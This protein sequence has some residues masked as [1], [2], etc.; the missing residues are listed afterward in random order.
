MKTKERARRSLWKKGCGAILLAF[1][2]AMTGQTSVNDSYSPWDSPD[3][4]LQTIHC[5]VATSKA[6]NFCGYK[7]HE[8]IGND[9]PDSASSIRA[10]VTSPTEK[11]AVILTGDWT[12]PG[13]AYFLDLEENAITYTF[14]DTLSPAKAVFSADGNHLFLTSVIGDVLVV[15]I[16]KGE[17]GPSEPY[18]LW[19]QQVFWDAGSSTQP[20]IRPGTQE[21]LLFGE[22]ST[23][24]L[25]DYTSGS[26]LKVMPH[27]SKSVVESKQARYRD[28]L[29]DNARFSP[30]ANYLLTHHNKATYLWD[31]RDH[32]H[33]PIGYF[34]NVRPEQVEFNEAGEPFLG[35][36]GVSLP[37]A[38]QTGEVGIE[39]LL[40]FEQLLF[41]GQPSLG[42]DYSDCLC[43]GPP[44]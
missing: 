27:Q 1:G 40:F 19:R 24:Y 13:P 10:V 12:L 36:T 31:L 35:E 21:V 3:V 26:L 16:Y 18:P 5:D 34:E 8:T 44:I 9:D 11:E 7:L 28:E 2:V 33:E 37:D 41:A 39:H 32:L 29:V 6:E 38:L 30:D 17:A 14:Q 20:V 23:I 42:T 43:L 22:D 4:P 25:R 15:K